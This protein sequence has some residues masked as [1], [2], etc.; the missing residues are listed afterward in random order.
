MN[1]DRKLHLTITSKDYYHNKTIQHKTYVSRKLRSAFDQTK[2]EHKHVLTY[3]VK[4]PKNTCSE[5]YLCETGRRLN[6][7]IMKHAGKDNKSHM[8]KNM[9]QSGHPAVSPNNFK[10]LQKG[11]NSKVKRKILKRY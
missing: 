10:I 4:C 2:L 7:R 8:L 11:H 1:R 5:T 6:E 3:L 9:L